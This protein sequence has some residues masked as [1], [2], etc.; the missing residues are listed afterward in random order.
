VIAFGGN[1][2]VNPF[3]GTIDKLAADRKMYKDKSH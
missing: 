1:L 3:K 2:E